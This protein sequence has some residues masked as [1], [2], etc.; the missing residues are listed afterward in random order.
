MGLADSMGLTIH[1][2][3]LPRE[4]RARMGVGTQRHPQ[5]DGGKRPRTTFRKTYAVSWNDTLNP[6][7]AQP[8]S[9]P[10]IIY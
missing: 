9:D 4:Q 3:C 6:P 10:C 7:K 1:A 2:L 8:S 5:A